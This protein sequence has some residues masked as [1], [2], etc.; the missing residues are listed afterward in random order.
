MESRQSAKMSRARRLLIWTSCTARS[1]VQCATCEH[2]ISIASWK[3]ILEMD[4]HVLSVATS[5]HRLGT[6]E[7]RKREEKPV[8]L[9][10]FLLYDW[11]TTFCGGNHAMQRHRQDGIHPI[12]TFETVRCT[13][14]Q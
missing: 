2:G 3:S 1:I 13:E 11:S 8:E 7:A 9:L 6:Y 5:V 4:M 10:I 14:T 12:R